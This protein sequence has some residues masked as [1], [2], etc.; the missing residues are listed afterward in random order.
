MPPDFR[1][2]N[3]WALGSGISGPVVRQKVMVGGMRENGAVHHTV[4][5]GT[6]TCRE[7]KEKVYC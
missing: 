6:E 5:R 4:D 3:E 2:F 1:S 7:T